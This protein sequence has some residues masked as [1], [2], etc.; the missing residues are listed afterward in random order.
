MALKVSPSPKLLQNALLDQ[1]ESVWFGNLSMEQWPVLLT[2]G[3]WPVLDPANWR[4]WKRNNQVFKKAERQINT[5]QIVWYMVHLD[6]QRHHL[7]AQ[8]KTIENNSLGHQ[9]VFKGD[10]IH[11]IKWT[12][13]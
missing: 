2:C 12:L 4:W 8:V 9:K 11:L 6:M 3:M 5:M 10:W 1:G 7:I 13:I